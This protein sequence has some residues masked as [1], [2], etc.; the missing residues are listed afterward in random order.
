MSLQAHTLVNKP[1]RLGTNLVVTTLLLTLL[2]MLVFV[3][4]VIHLGGHT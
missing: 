4:V 3:L 2:F 1:K